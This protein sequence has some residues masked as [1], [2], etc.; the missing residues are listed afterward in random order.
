MS[1]RLAATSRSDRGP[2]R[3]EDERAPGGPESITPEG[4]FLLLLLIVAG[5]MSALLLL[6]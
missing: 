2:G 1:H 3:P 5:V 4:W 6:A